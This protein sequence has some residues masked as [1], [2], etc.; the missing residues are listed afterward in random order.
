MA[1]MK[2][3]VMPSMQTGKLEAHPELAAASITK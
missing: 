3:I 1:I 2:S